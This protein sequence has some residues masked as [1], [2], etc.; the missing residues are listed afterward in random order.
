MTNCTVYIFAVDALNAHLMSAF[1]AQHVLSVQRA[2]TRVKNK[3]EASVIVFI[4]PLE[5]AIVMHDASRPFSALAYC[6]MND[7]A[8]F[9]ATPAMDATRKIGMDFFVR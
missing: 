7:S 8:R 1:S 2:V 6:V 4:S 5:A 9:S 3:H